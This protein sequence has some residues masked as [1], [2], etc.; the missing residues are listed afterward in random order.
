MKFYNLNFIEKTVGFFILASFI[1]TSSFGF[2]YILEKTFLQDKALVKNELLLKELNTQKPQNKLESAL[3]NGPVNKGKLETT[4]FQKKNNITLNTVK[5]YLNILKSEEIYQLYHDQNSEFI[6]LYNTQIKDNLSAYDKESIQAIKE[7]MAKENS[8]MATQKFNLE[9]AISS[10]ERFTKVSYKPT[11][12]VKNIMAIQTPKTPELAKEVFLKNPFH[13]QKSILETYMARDILPSI[14][15]YYK[16]NRAF[17]ENMDNFSKTLQQLQK[18]KTNSD[19]KLYIKDQEQLTAIKKKI[20]ETKYNLLFQKCKISFITGTLIEDVKNTPKK[21]LPT[22]VKEDKLPKIV[23]NKVSTTP[24]KEAQESDISKIKLKRIHFVGNDDQVS[25]YSINI[26]KSHAQI[27]KNLKNYTLELYGHSDSNPG[28]TTN[29]DLSL[30]RAE[31][32]KKALVKFGVDGSRI[33]TFGMGDKHP[34]ATNATKHGRLMNRRVEF[35]LIENK[36]R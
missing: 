2:E 14:S 35:K 32:T 31:N 26:V 17:E 11:S 10:F 15:E 21:E 33:K 3:K 23:S 16:E 5:F 19:I 12:V 29:K 28:T 34:I 27:L 4:I 36:D 18:Q 20:I 8:N 25:S 24:F 30:N 1:T 7:S 9:S 6:K 22:S 13:I